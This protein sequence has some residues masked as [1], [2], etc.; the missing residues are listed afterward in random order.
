MDDVQVIGGFTEAAN[1]RVQR[2]AVVMVVVVDHN[3]D[4]RQRQRL[5]S[6]IILPLTITSLRASSVCGPRTDCQL[7]KFINVHFSS[8]RDVFGTTQGRHGIRG[9]ALFMSLFANTNVWQASWSWMSS[10]SS[11]VVAQDSF[12]LSTVLP[13]V[14]QCHLMADELLLSRMEAL[15]DS[16]RISDCFGWLRRSLQSEMKATGK[17]CA[18]QSLWIIRANH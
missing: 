3:I 6:M 18:S 11:F 15:E 5:A 16:G 17:V 7:P 14:A 9:K 2:M 10:I 12:I 13:T 1:V 8:S 4:Q